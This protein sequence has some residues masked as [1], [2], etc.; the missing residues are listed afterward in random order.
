[1]GQYI[2]KLTNNICMCLK[3]TS[4]HSSCCDDN[5]DID[6]KNDRKQKD[7]ERHFNCCFGCFEYE[8][9]AFVHSEHKD[10]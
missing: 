10:K 5:I 2:S 8:S 7:T 9:E 6:V 1:M 4:C 3:Y